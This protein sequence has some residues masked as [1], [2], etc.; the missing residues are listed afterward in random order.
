MKRKTLNALIAVTIAVSI[1]LCGCA[2]ADNTEQT[3][4]VPIDTVITSD[5]NNDTNVSDEA[6]N[7]D[8]QES[9]NETDIK[10]KSEPIIEEEFEEPQI[11]VVQ[12][13]GFLWERDGWDSK[14]VR[15]IERGDVLYILGR[16]TKNYYLTSEGNY[17]D[18]T[19]MLTRE[20]FE[21]A[22]YK[23]YIFNNL[24]EDIT[25]YAQS[26]TSIKESTSVDAE[27]SSTANAG[28]EITVVAI[29]DDGSYY[30]LADGT[31]IIADALGESKP[32]AQN[33]TQSQPSTPSQ[34]QTSNPPAMVADASQS[35]AYSTTTI[36]TPSSNPPAAS[37]DDWWMSNWDN[38]PTYSTG[39]GNSGG[40]SSG[41]TTTTIV[42]G[43]DTV[44][45]VYTY[46][47]YLVTGMVGEIN[48][49]RN[50]RGKGEVNWE[51]TWETE[52]LQRAREIAPNNG[53]G[54]W[55]NVKHKY[56]TAATACECIAGGF[57]GNSASQIDQQYANSPLHDAALHNEDTTRICSANCDVYIDGVYYASYNVTYFSSYY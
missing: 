25:L 46:N 39:N 57:W 50:A 11:Y 21:E 6:D 3:Q 44:N 48:A 41:S 36:T 15:G 9:V 14:S 33:P 23:V 10:E 13:P 17:V 19:K 18:A 32:Q 20:E 55:D 5:V 30:M 47:C 37:G 29:S 7:I 34:N 40:S 26:N 4:T 43:P 35:P 12:Y 42:T 27:T 8:I 31:V 49:K 28:D 16:T 56:G 52:V 45:G 2:D 22:Y 24:D 51:S 54:M 53:Q 38:A 1:S